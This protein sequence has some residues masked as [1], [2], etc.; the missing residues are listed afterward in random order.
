[1]SAG[2]A[3]PLRSRPSKPRCRTRPCTSPCRGAETASNWSG[4]GGVR[5]GQCPSADGGRSAGRAG[6][7]ALEG[8]DPLDAHHRSRRM[9]VPPLNMTPL[10]RTGPGA[11]PE[12]DRPGQRGR[13]GRTGATCPPPLIARAPA[14]VGRAKARRYPLQRSMR[15]GEGDGGLPARLSPPKAGAEKSLCPPCP[16]ARSVGASWEPSKRSSPPGPRHGPGF[17]CS[18]TAPPPRTGFRESVAEAHRHSVPSPDDRA[19]LSL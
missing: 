6:F 1:M 13:S 18:A 9:A 11:G 5:R 15:S 7:P 3:S 4:G 17:S 2:V 12:S 10:Q 14:P 8:R 19:R 16:P